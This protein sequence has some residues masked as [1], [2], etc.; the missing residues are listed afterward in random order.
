MGVITLIRRNVKNTGR[1][2]VFVDDEF[3]AACPIDVAAALGLRKGLT[4]TP[5]MEQRLRAEDRKVVL[6]QKA[7][8]YATYKPRTERQVRDHLAKLEVTDEESEDVL[9]WLAEFRL[10]DDVDYARRFVEAAKERKPLSPSDAKRKLKMKGVPDDVIDQVLEDAYD[11]E[12]VVDAARRVAEK[13]MRM[14]KGDARERKRKLTQFLQYRGYTWS[15]VKRVVEEMSEHLTLVVFLMVSAVAS[16]A[17]TVLTCDKTRLPESINAFQPTT[18]PV[19]SPDGRLFLDRKLH[20]DNADGITDPDD[21]WIAVRRS[22]LAWSEPSQTPFTTVRRPDVVFNFTP[23]G[24]C[25]LVVGRYGSGGGSP[26][27][28]FAILSRRSSDAPFDRIEVLDVG[29][30]GT[31][32]YGFLSADRQTVLLALERSGGRGDLDLYVMRS[33]DTAWSDL[34]SLGDSVNTAGL[35]GSPWLAQDGQTL[36]FVSNGRDDRRG[37]ADVYRTQRQGS[38]W[39]SWT[40]PVNMGSC[41]NSQEDETSIS[42]DLDERTAYLTSWDAEVDRPGVY[43]VSIPADHAPLPVCRY[44]PEVLDGMTMEPILDYTVTAV[45]SALSKDRCGRTTY[46]S[47]TAVGA[48]TICIPEGRSYRLETYVPG[49]TTHTQT[50]TVRDLDSTVSL[51][52]TVRVFNLKR[53]LGSVYFS[54]GSAKLSDSATQAIVDIVERYRSLRVRFYVDGYTDRVGGDDANEQL[55]QDRAAAVAAELLEAGMSADRVTVA[56]KGVERVPGVYDEEYPQSRRVDIFA[57]SE[58]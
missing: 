15:V 43:T 9:A 5:E 18:Q 46:V 39:T 42:L 40:R 20:P 26:E 38:D 36:F 7:Y 13:K 49:Y 41:V 37:K 33:C 28:R 27:P 50:I 1:C 58:D 51:V 19:L 35:E 56:G 12:V 21:V 4:M 24:L 32:Y 14:L 2:S 54:R 45:D 3:F 53:P 30:L 55:S 22:A 10:I 34:R 23:D 17:Q 29:T 47:D 52:T 31:N 57:R 8:R 16:S 25:A 44:T 48:A 6:R 11:E